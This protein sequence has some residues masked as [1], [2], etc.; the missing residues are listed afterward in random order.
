VRVLV[1]VVAGCALLV[2]A[3]R[4]VALDFGAPVRASLWS[5]QDG[6]APGRSFTLG[7][8][9][10]H[11]PG[12]HSYWIVPGDAGLPTRLT[13]SLPPGFRA[14]PIQWPAPRRLAVGPLVDYGYEGDTL[15]LTDVQP[16]PDLLPGGEVRI[17]AKAQWL[18]CHDV[19]IPGS[20]DLVVTLPVREVGALHATAEAPAFERARS[21]IPRER[22]LARAAATL[23]NGHVTLQFALPAEGAPHGLE[24]F[25]LE[26]GRIEP[27]AP[28]TVRVA[29]DT[30]QLDLTAAQP[31]AADFRTLHGVLAV[32]GGPDAGGWAGTIEVPI[33]AN[34]PN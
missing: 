2:C 6:V 33:T 26:A 16:G 18:M 15:L 28:Q 20:Q 10:L 17:E 3:M 9:L 23:A 32:D 11:A 25:P 8:R 4:A 5:E 1:A 24:F 14:G 29:A 7:L 12:W 30:V 22:K 21:H 31:I 34:S 27:S 13:W 19:C